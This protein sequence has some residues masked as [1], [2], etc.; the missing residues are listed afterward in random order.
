MDLVAPG[1]LRVTLLRWLF[2][3]GAPALTVVC[4]ATF[5]L[6]P[7]QSPLAPQQDEPNED[8][9]YWD[10]D[11]QRSLSAPSDLVPF[12][13]RGDVV[14]VG[15]AYAQQPVRSLVA[16]LSVGTIDKSIEVCADR[17][18]G[19][20]G[21][22]REGMPFAKMRLRYERAAGGAETWNPV[23]MR[24]DV[25]DAR[26]NVVLPNLQPVGAQ[27]TRR[28]DGFGPIGFGPIAPAWRERSGKVHR[29]T[30]GWTP[31]GWAARPLPDGFDASFFNV[32]PADQQLDALRGDEPILLE[33]LH[34]EHPRLQTRLADIAP[35]A[36][37]ERP[38]QGPQPLAFVCDTMLIDTDRGV[39]H[40]VWRATVRL[41]HPAEAGRIVVSGGQEEAEP[42][43]K[44]GPSSGGRV[45]DQT[46][47]PNGLMASM[48]MPF[49]RGQEAPPP[50][51]RPSAPAQGSALPFGRTGSFQPVQMPPPSAPQPPPPASKGSFSMNEG[52]AIVEIPTGA[53]AAVQAPVPAPP[54][55]RPAPPPPPPPGLAP[56]GL[57]PSGMVPP[58]G[59]APSGMVPPPGLAPSGMAPVP[60]PPPPGLAPSGMVPPPAMPP[61]VAPPAMALPGL[62]PSGLAPSGLAP[63]PAMPAPVPLPAAPIETSPWAQGAASSPNAPQEAPLSRGSVGERMMLDGPAETPAPAK[64]APA[65]KQRAARVSTEAVALV[66]FDPGSVARIR[67]RPAWRNLLVDLEND[68]EP[69]AEEGALGNTPEEIEDRRDMLHVLVHGSPIDG[70][71]ISEALEHGVRADGKIIN[72]LVLT[73]G[74]LSFTFDELEMLKA[75]LSAAMPFTAGDEALTAAAASAK[76]FLTTPG[77]IATGAVIESLT[78]RLREA[79]LRVKRPVPNDYLTVQGE[80]ALLEKRHYQKREVF[81]GTCL[82]GLFQPVGAADP[83][84]CYLPEEVS[85]QLPLYQR[86][87]VRLI[88]EVHRTADQNEVHPAALKALALGRTLNGRG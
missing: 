78:A 21:V 55:P 46:I 24:F 29:A 70:Y 86:F 36:T 18:I 3:N 51:P 13:A 33:H 72:P 65:P 14:L 66:W 15:S 80:R 68:P 59:L 52:T 64:I 60:P 42:S 49:A 73:A 81:S 35:R 28:G 39:C 9:T 8:D 37:V 63:S 34:A 19:V 88:A 12:K 2:S 44:E 53:H 62:A 27:I 1:P 54:P 48:F 43:W 77:L 30:P 58:P 56:S 71:G 75:T 26:G 76:E 79:F 47:A 69:D 82:R 41:S 22:L 16:R 57:A 87:P 40:L 83:I 84:P 61:P 85:K 74:Q 23:G 11:S 31:Y 67:R 20:D 7:G 10:D 50:A 45:R 38:G 6:R 5:S 4:K 17:A 32:A 25:A